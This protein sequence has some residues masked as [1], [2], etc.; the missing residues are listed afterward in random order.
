MGVNF[1]EHEWS[2]TDNMINLKNKQFLYPIGNIGPVAA[3][4]TNAP[5]DQSDSQDST[6][7]Q[8]DSQDSTT[9]ASVSGGEGSGSG[10]PTTTDNTPVASSSVI[11]SVSVF[12]TVFLLDH[13]YVFCLRPAPALRTS[14]R[15]CVSV[16]V[17]VVFRMWVGI[18]FDEMYGLCAPKSLVKFDKYRHMVSNPCKVCK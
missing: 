3:D 16:V 13:L 8:S 10:D 7:D 15:Y 18:L 17:V 14:L 2:R 12:G 5:G 6:G 9:R 11:S 4:N 1:K